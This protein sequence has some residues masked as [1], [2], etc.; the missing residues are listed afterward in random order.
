MVLIV[1][2]EAIYSELS[3]LEC[4]I[5]MQILPKGTLLPGEKKENQ[6]ENSAILSGEKKSNYIVLGRKEFALRG[7]NH[8]HL[9]LMCAVRLL[10][11]L[12]FH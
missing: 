9:Q 10:L 8:H 2:D 11:L 7:E 3:T 5:F 4:E 6:R 1:G 12:P